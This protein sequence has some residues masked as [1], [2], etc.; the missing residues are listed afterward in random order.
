MWKGT[1]YASMLTPPLS[2]FPAATLQQCVNVVLSFGTSRLLYWTASPFTTLRDTSRL[3]TRDST[4]HVVLRHGGVCCLVASTGGH[5]SSYKYCLYGPSLIYL[6]LSS[7]KTQQ[8]ASLISFQW[9]DISQRP[10]MKDF[11]ECDD[12]FMLELNQR[13]TWSDFRGFSCE[14]N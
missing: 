12:I 3:V 7:A 10:R 5:W 13:A 2:Y 6:I 9:E 11:L 1:G 4:W 8:I 14:W